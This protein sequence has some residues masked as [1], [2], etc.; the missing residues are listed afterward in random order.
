MPT[1]TS[2]PVAGM[3]IFDSGSFVFF[4]IFSVDMSY[5]KPKN[6]LAG[7]GYFLEVFKIL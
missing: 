3:S 2:L 4:G 7:M 5:F 6:A 1:A